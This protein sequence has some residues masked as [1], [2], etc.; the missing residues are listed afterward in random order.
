METLGRIS[1]CPSFN[2]STIED[3]TTGAIAVQGYTATQGQ[4]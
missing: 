1:K 4:L 2:G 3:T